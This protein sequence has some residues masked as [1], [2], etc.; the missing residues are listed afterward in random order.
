[1]SHRNVHIR[2]R[3]KDEAKSRRSNLLA[4]HVDEKLT[5]GSKAELRKRGEWAMREFAKKS[6][7]QSKP[8]AK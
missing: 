4:R 8:G 1:M 5:S 6:K 3:T 2:P 7:E